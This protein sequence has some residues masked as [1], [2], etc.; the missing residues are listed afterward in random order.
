MNAE[1]PC[2]PVC[3]NEYNAKTK[4]GGQCRDIMKK[5]KNKVVKWYGAL[6]GRHARRR[7]KGIEPEDNPND[8]NDQ[9]LNEET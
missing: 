9:V 3:F 5:L 1:Y 7:E 4:D 8:C 2:E 6:R